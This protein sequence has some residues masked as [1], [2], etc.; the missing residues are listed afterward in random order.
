MKIHLHRFE[1]ESAFTGIHMH[2]ING[3]VKNPFGFN[4][5]HF[6]FYY[7]V[8]SYLDHTHHFSGITGMPIKT[9]NGHIHKIEGI[10]EKSNF[11]IHK[12]KGYTF[13]DSAC[14][15]EGQTAGSEI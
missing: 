1:V 3:Y 4:R 7:G 11:H 9:E 13:E 6:H 2:I 8:S 12:F 5:F 14:I 10:L 15:H